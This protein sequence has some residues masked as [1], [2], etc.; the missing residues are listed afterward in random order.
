MVNGEYEERTG[1]DVEKRLSWAKAWHQ[2]RRCCSALWLAHLV[3]DYDDSTLVM[4]S[5]I[6]RRWCSYRLK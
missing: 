4:L 5:V 3:V 6:F 1:G 2:R